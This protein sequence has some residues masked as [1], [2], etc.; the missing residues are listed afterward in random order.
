MVQAGANAI[1]VWP[2][3]PTALNQAIH[4]A[5][6]QG[7]VVVTY[8]ALASDSSVGRHLDLIIWRF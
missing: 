7:V 8:V 4:N 6:N 3:S 1:A 5:C 2:I